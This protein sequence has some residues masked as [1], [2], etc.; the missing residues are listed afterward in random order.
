MPSEAQHLRKADGNQRF[1]ESLNLAQDPNA[2]WAIVAL[3]YS[4]VHRV[5]A[6]LAR[7]FNLHSTN[8]EQRKK[9]MARI[10]TMRICFPE[11]SHLETLSRNCRYEAKL[12]KFNDY[13]KARPIFDKFKSTLK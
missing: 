7:D 8:H 2:E 11:Y 6:V 5:E 12:F 3:F 10:G 13:E 1:A 4:A 9:T